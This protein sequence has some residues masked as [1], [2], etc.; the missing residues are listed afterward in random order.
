MIKILGSNCKKWRTEHGYYQLDVA[1]DT[2]YSLENVS[3]FENGRNDNCR[4][5][6]W[7][8]IKG[9]SLHELYLG[10]PWESFFPTSDEEF[11]ENNVKGGDECEEI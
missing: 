7:Y 2:G 10:T 6:S 5:L 11:E 9:M 4:F 8:L 1:H 3:A